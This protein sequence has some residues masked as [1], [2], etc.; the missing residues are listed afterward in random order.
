M[1]GYL[2]SVRKRAVFA[3]LLIYSGRTVDPLFA[4]TE[5]PFRSDG[6]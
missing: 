1:F 3:S 4:C 2:F 5:E 6:G